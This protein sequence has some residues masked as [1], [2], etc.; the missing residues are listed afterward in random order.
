MKKE[1]LY[2]GGID[3]FSAE[4]YYKENIWQLS[5]IQSIFVC[6]YP[7]DAA[8][9]GCFMAGKR[10]KES[11]VYDLET[12][13]FVIKDMEGKELWL[14]GLPC[15]FYGTGPRKALEV[16]KD[17]DARGKLSF[18]DSFD[19]LVRALFDYPVVRITVS[20]NDEPLQIIGEPSILRDDYPANQFG[21]SSLNIYKGEP[22]LAVERPVSGA[23]VT[24]L[25]DHFKWFVPQPYE[26]KILTPLDAQES[27]YDWFTLRSCPTEYFLSLKDVSK[28]EIVLRFFHTNQLP[29]MQQETVLEVLNHFGIQQTIP[30][31]SKK[32]KSWVLRQFAP[33]DTE[34]TPLIFQFPFN[35]NQS[36]PSETTDL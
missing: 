16:F 31:I 17:L 35:F 8:M 7:M 13:T 28:R 34:K 6:R 24:T 22:I 27:G 20:S 32:V 11:E 23:S 36:V 33:E 12:P 26:L 29:L 15:G 25:L 9:E 2:S 14:S 18:N 1:I 5:E 19:E 30:S 3:S 21:K 4:N 10:H